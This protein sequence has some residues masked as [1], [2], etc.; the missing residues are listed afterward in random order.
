M[1]A[2]SDSTTPTSTTESGS[3]LH[4][5][6]ARIS[7]WATWGI[8]GVIGVFALSQPLLWGREW[9]MGLAVPMMVTEGMVVVSVGLFL[10]WAGL[11]SWW[12]SLTK[13]VVLIPALALI[14]GFAG[15]VRNLDLN[16][17]IGINFEF[18]WEPTQDERI[19]AHRAQQAALAAAAPVA[20]L[21]TVTPEDMPAYRGVHR[22]GVVIGPPIRTTWESPPKPL[23]Q[24]P[25]GGGY[26]SV[27]IVGDRLVTIEQRE[28][29]EAVICYQAST[30]RELWTH[31][32]PARFWEAMG[33]PGPR[34]TPTIDGDLVFAQ[35]AMGDLVCLELAKGKVRWSK[36]LL[37]LFQLPNSEWGLTSSP[38]IVDHRVIANAG[39]RRGDGLVALDRLTGDLIW[40]GAGLKPGAA[41]AAPI[42]EASTAPPPS[43]DIGH[44]TVAESK[45]NRPGYSSPT[46]VTIHGVRQIL[47]FDGTGLR[48]HDPE[49]GQVLWF[50]PHENGP[51][52]NAA[53]PILLDEGRIFI[54]CSY[55]VGGAMVQV[56][57]NGNAWSVNELWQNENMRC[58]FSSPVLHEGFLYGLDEGIL[59]C[60]D[61]QTGDRKW[62]KGRYNHGQLM[63]T[64]GIL[65][66]LTEDGRCVFV[67]PSPEQH[68]ELG[69]F[70]ALSSDYKTWNPPSLVRGKLY[71]RNH[72][73]MA[74]YDL[75]P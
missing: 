16:G 4:N 68:E 24:Q 57:R 63:L 26:G 60:L 2:D 70:P 71:V 13:A 5:R 55:R 59:V 20:E 53:Q 72:H 6:W 25:C 74:C 14:G 56:L 58:K 41:S 1:A 64:N 67:K 10:V 22:D 37:T 36:H 33:G 30:G 34:S 29:N 73:D 69:Q 66:V 7:R 15:S 8:F 12:T 54:S 38:L 23:W 40:S 48:G 62:K 9:R 46:L 21:P 52:V 19:A 3:A 43:D 45:R 35:G 61:P 28:T 32:Y 44:V 50:H 27:A 39:G 42:S 17:D 18:R 31:Q 65:V 75:N 51:A 11:F 49:S 47:N